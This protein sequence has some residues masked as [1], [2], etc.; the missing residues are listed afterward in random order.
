MREHI[1][2]G[3]L[4]GRLAAVAAAA[5]LLSLSACAPTAV[6]EPEE[7]SAETGEQVA[8]E[9]F[10]RPSEETVPPVETEP[11]EQEEWEPGFEKH[12]IVGSD[13]H[14]LS[15][16]LTD[17][18]EAFQYDVEHGDGRLVTYIDQITDAFLEEVAE[19][20]PDVLIL[21]GDLTTNGELASHEGLAEK[22]RWLEEQG[23]PVVVIP[24]NHDL[25][26]PRAYGYRGDERYP[27]ERTTP[28]QFRQIYGEF[29]YDEAVS[30][31]A[32]TLSYVWQL[33]GM[34]RLLML[35]TCQYRDGNRVGGVILTETYDWIE[36]QLEEAWEEGM[37]IIPVAHHNLLEESEVYT[38]DCTIEH[39]EQLVD[40]LGE[41]N[42]NIFLSGHLHVQHWMEE[43]DNNLY[44]IVSSSMTTPECKY[45]L[46]TYRDDCSFSYH[47]EEVDVEK[48]AAENGRTEEELLHFTEFRRPFLEQVFKN[49][50]YGVLQHM[51]EITE[52]ER[53]Q[54]CE[55]YAWV[56]YM[57]YQGKAVEIRDA[58][59]EDPAYGLWDSKG[60]ITVLR[61]YVVSILNDAKR[62]YN[63]LEVE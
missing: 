24:G 15:P 3:R 59:Y 37:N 32:T 17:Y 28:E 6:T 19:R 20:Q 26:N 2:G 21:C 13:I 62:D 22:L 11:P 57:Y 51:E 40:I 8:P 14:Y 43:E 46:L 29:G 35:D 4:T 60:Y 10:P 33:D 45:G 9:T 47:T 1:F 58:A 7:P 42:V 61:D 54:M 41:W 48:W 5:A 52:E 55:Y 31:D 23:V 25:N 27:A 34:T 12:I 56:N 36:E 38:V 50:A 53:L 63:Y 39:S 30:E 18:G 49:E 44:E 16:E